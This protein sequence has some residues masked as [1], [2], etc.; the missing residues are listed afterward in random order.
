MMEKHDNAKIFF[1]YAVSGKRYPLMMISSV[2]VGTDCEILGT[3]SNH[4]PQILLQ[5]LSKFSV[6]SP[7]RITEGGR[8]CSAVYIC[9]FQLH[10]TSSSDWNVLSGSPCS[11]IGQDKFLWELCVFYRVVRKELPFIVTHTKS[12]SESGLQS[13][14]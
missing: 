9:M 6:S 5:H 8:E 7:K 3:L 1:S 4:N 14:E 13:S 10:S 12:A 11:R 2:S